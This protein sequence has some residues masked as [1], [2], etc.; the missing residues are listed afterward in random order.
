MSWE[1]AVRIAMARSTVRE[2]IKFTYARR[3][4]QTF[5]FYIAICKDLS[6]GIANGMF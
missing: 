4:P 5:N 2:I 1:S 3:L 6:F